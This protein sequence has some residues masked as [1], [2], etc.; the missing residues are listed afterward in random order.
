[1]KK[2]IQNITSNKKDTLGCLST[3]QSLNSLQS[4]TITVKGIVEY[5]E[6]EKDIMSFV[7]DKGY[8][9]SIS[10]TVKECIQNMLTVFG[11]DDILQGIPV[12]IVH[13]KSRK[14]REFLLL[15]L[16]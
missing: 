6:D 5:T 15:E 10:V 12:K 4:D 3:T 16:I 7:T 14:G 9:N 13:K 8:I 2:I 11:A 1:M